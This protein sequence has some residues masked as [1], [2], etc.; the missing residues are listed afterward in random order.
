MGRSAGSKRKLKPNAKAVAF[1]VI[2]RDVC[3]Q[4]QQMCTYYGWCPSARLI[5][6]REQTMYTFLFSK[7]DPSVVYKS[8]HCTRLY[9]NMS[10]SVVG[11]PSNIL[12]VF[13]H[14][15]EKCD[16]ILPHLLASVRTDTALDT[17]KL[18]S[19]VVPPDKQT[20]NIHD[21]P[22]VDPESNTDNSHMFQQLIAELDRVCS[23]G[24]EDQFTPVCR[25]CK[26][27]KFV[28]LTQQQTRSA[29]EGMT[30]FAT[31]KKCN[32]EWRC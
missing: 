9:R 8:P 15:K 23:D 13:I 12:H 17:A 25:K 28:E 14:N 30:N 31:C 24:K 18:E 11:L 21:D 10:Y 32:T 26:T 5:A 7:Y 16:V 20:L 1:Q 4:L 3:A 29:D 22:G 6:G 2:R 19:C 27:N